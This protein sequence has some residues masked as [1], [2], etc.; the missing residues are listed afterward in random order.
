MI[1]LSWRISNTHVNAEQ[2]EPPL[3]RTSSWPIYPEKQETVKKSPYVNNL[4]TEYIRFTLTT[5]Q[6]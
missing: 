5:A 1:L 6:K 3:I 2:W 4:S